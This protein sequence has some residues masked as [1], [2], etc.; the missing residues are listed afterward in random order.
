MH[1]NITMETLYAVFMIILRYDHIQG[2][3]Q[4]LYYLSDISLKWS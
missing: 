4:C 1:W 3:E 2:V